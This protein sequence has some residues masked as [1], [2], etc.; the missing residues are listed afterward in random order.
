MN[1][2]A[3]DKLLRIA[4]TALASDAQGGAPIDEASI[5]S[6]VKQFASIAGKGLD[7]EAIESVIKEITK[8]FNVWTGSAQMLVGADPGHKEWISSKRESINWTFWNRYR[9]HG[10]GKLPPKVVVEL[11]ESTTTV[12]GLLEDPMRGGAWRRQGLVVGHVQSGK[13]GHYTGL[14]CKA[15]DA[16]Y[17]VVIVLSGIHNSLRAQTQI[18]LDEGFLGYAREFGDASRTR[19]PVGVGLL[20]GTP[21]ADSVTTRDERGDF[22]RQKAQG[23]QIHAGGNVLLFVVKKNAKVLKNLIEWAKLSAKKPGEDGRLV[24]GEVPLLVIDDE[25]DQASVDTKVQAFDEETGAPDPDH[26]PKAINRLIRILLNTFERRA[27]VGYTATPFANVFVH[28]DGWTKECGEDLFPKHFIINL[29]APNDYFGPARVFGLAESGLPAHGRT[30][31]RVRFV[32]DADSWVPPSHKAGLVPRVEGKDDVPSSLHEAIRSF[33]LACAARRTRGQETQH[34]SM[35]VHVTRF[36]AVQAQVHHQVRRAVENLKTR[37]RARKTSPGD[38]LLAELQELW[39][40]D[41]ALTS[42]A[43]GG[44]HVQWSLIEPHVWPVLEMVKVMQ[45]NAKASDALIYEEHKKNG[46]HVIAIGGDKLSRGLTLEG[47]TVS[48]FLRSARMY[49]T[50]MQMG[51]WFGY[52]P[53]YEDLCRLYLT[54]ELAEWYGHITEAANELRAEFDRMVLQGSTPDDYGLRVRTHPVLAITGKLRPGLPT[55]TTS[56]SAT[57]FEPTVLLDAPE[58][59]RKNWKRTERFLADLGEPGMAPVCRFDPPPLE[60]RG[61]WA[62]SIAWENVPGTKVLGFLKEFTFADKHLTRTPSVAVRDYITARLAANELQRWTVV[63]YGKSTSSKAKEDLPPVTVSIGRHVIHTIFR[64]IA[65]KDRVDVFS[66]KRLGSPR[67]ESIDLSEA[68]WRSVLEVAGRIS[69]DPQKS[70]ELTRNRLVRDARPRDRGLMILYLLTP[71][72]ERVGQDG[73]DK[74]L[75]APFISFP[76]TPSAK[77]ITYKVG[78][79]YWEEELGGVE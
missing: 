74:P 61:E 45:I 73:A 77:P 66:T 14:I 8:R 79:R 44:G 51:R 9:Q 18:R 19:V 65:Q 30:P 6:T 75:V 63:A 4:I 28:P 57:P 11:D 42:D 12:L 5:V 54:Q 31:S 25:A 48:Y 26:D 76:F 67:D 41:F 52:R 17:K 49:D 70:R 60:R 24:V 58:V 20:D 13:T 35:L 78:I 16:G 34:K 64:S 69:D 15:A 50:L 72:P 32:T 1:T 68:E 38:P 37:W 40:N 47:L 71:Y 33:V 29:S 55:I 21:I 46:L 62:G 43:H 59:H 7:D 2:Q 39:N 23:F 10:E 53:G 3:N 27:Y 56:L 22:S 36:T